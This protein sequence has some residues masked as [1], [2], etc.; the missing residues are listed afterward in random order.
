MVKHLAFFLFLLLPLQSF[1]QDGLLS[2]YVDR[3]E[4]SIND[5][6]TLTLRVNAELRGTRPNIDRLQQDFELIGSSERNSFTFINGVSEQWSEFRISLRPRSTGTLTI[7]AFRVGNEVTTP[8]T[9]TVAE[10]IQNSVNAD[11]FFLISTVS[12]E[13]IYVQEQL[14]YTVKI[15]FS[16]PFDPG[17]QLGAPQTENAVI[18]QLG[19]DISSQEVIDGL[20]YNV[21][22]R[23]FVLFPQRSGSMEI[24][25]I[26]FT[27]TVG[28]RRTGSIFSG[29]MTGGRAINL[30]SAAHFINVQSKPTSYPAD[31]TWLPSSNLIL[32]E[33]WSRSLQ[34]L[35]TGEA[36]T[37]NL[38]VRAE[39]LNSSLLP[40]IQYTA[41]ETLKFYPDQ[42]SREDLANQNGVTGIRSQGTAVV[43]TEG[44]DFIL[45]ALEIA[46]W[47]TLTDSLEYASLPE[48]ILSVLPAAPITEQAPPT[49][50]A[51]G[52]EQALESSSGIGQQSDSA[53]Y[54]ILA[55]SIFAL[56]WLYSTLMWYRSKL[57]LKQFAAGILA[58]TASLKEKSSL[59]SNRK[60]LNVDAAFQE[61]QEACKELKLPEIRL[62][63]LTWARLHFADNK[64]ITLENLERHTENTDLQAIFAGLEYSLYSGNTNSENFQTGLLFQEIKRLHKQGYTLKNNTAEHYALPPLYKN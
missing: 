24:S 48:R 2:A 61:F 50:P 5:V 33:N 52:I 12:K 20:R 35:E 53:Y 47:N 19:N 36:I 7:P 8:I 55:T 27:A 38:R 60:K 43:A 25:P 6:F 46:W 15:Y 59:N 32:E 64:I 26:T 41:T 1:A 16:V 14:L 29:Q 21:I 37:R 63:L 40:G 13:S 58:P 45:P 10:A 3:T 51:D 31:A 11:D 39:G 34:G 57:T 30:S 42:P 22:E 17:A 62:S 49:L 4:V 23:R 54:W 9:V 56:A 28:R 18:Q 44:G